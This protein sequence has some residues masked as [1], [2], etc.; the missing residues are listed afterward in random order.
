MTCQ[1]KTSFYIYIFQ[2]KIQRIFEEHTPS[3]ENDSI[4]FTGA[5]FKDNII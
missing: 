2:G 4:S 1:S 3:I 5:A